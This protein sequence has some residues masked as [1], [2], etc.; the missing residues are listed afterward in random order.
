MLTS[1]RHTARKRGRGIVLAALVAAVVLA[2][3]QGL[4]ARQ[5]V[6]RGIG[7][8]LVQVEDGRQMTL[9]E[10]SY[11]LV[12]GASEYD[13]GKGWAR[14]PGVLQDVREV[15]AALKE[16]GFKVEEVLNPTRA[17]LEQALWKFVGDYGQTANNRLLVYFAGHGATIKTEDGR[18]LGY[19]VPCD[20]P[21]PAN[22]GAF[23]QAA[24]SMESFQNLAKQIESRHALF[25]FDS[26]FSGSLFHSTMRSVPNHIMSKMASPVRQFIT[27]GTQEQAVP[28]KSIFREQFVRALRGEADGNNDRYV[29][30]TE[31]GVFLE[32]RVTEHSRRTQTP[33]WGKILDPGLNKGDFV[34]S[35]L[36]PGESPPQVA[37]TSEMAELAKI[38]DAGEL[39]HWVR[40]ANSTD[41]EDYKAF[42]EKH[43]NG[44][45]AP[46]AKIRAQAR[47][48]AAPNS[49]ASHP[50]PRE[51]P[52]PF[53]V[54]A[55]F[56]GQP[57]ARRP[58]AGAQSQPDTRPAPAV[59]R[60]APPKPD[61]SWYVILGSYALSQQHKA[62][63]LMLKYQALGYDAR[64]INSNWGDFPNFA[65]SLWVVVIGPGTQRAARELT[66]EIRPKVRAQPYYKQAVK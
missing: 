36:K 57:A 9:Y 59:T 48:P 21:L 30:G 10:Q 42:L 28:D 11:A 19:V 60:P 56:A 17:G 2:P 53:L 55:S 13:R 38:V 65:R 39:A 63:A 58:G 16:H 49:S 46:V 43:P 29:T 25:V 34:F 20:A 24:F 3:A 45:F 15:S 14:L 37:R 27:A 40:I 12:I 64:L 32:D 50:T 26:C 8:V 6:T 66:R 7:H 5:G 44:T 35:L 51:S 41:P 52:G 1:R 33:Q 31:L 18:D 23:K 62:N 4:P 22:K 47:T 54:R 61:E